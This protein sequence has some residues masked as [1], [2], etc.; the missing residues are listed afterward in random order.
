MI[1]AVGSLSLPGP[2]AR[3]CSEKSLGAGEAEPCFPPLLEDS[4]AALLEFLVHELG[5]LALG[6]MLVAG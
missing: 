5:I 4:E 1:E 6:E 2:G 3:A